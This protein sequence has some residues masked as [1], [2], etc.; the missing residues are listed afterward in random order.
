MLMQPFVE[1]AI[2]HGI[3]PNVK[4]GIITVNFDV[5]NE[6]LLVVIKDNGKG[7]SKEIA[8]KNHKSLATA[9]SKERLAIIAK[10]SGEAAGIEIKSEENKGTTVWLTIPIKGMV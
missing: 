1:N 4:G 6:T 8:V 10:Q 2:I 7:F 9:I 3:N 5:K